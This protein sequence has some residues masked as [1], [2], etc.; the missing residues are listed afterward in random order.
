MGHVRVAIKLAHPERRSDAVTI[1]GALVDAGATHVVL[2]RSIVE[3][4]GLQVIGQIRV[5]TA[6]G[7]QTLDQSYA[8]IELEGRETVTSVL[9]SDTLATVLVGVIALEG[10]GLAV[11]PSTGRLRDSEV[12][13]MVGAGR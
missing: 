12:L 7:L 2:P 3:S 8:Y 1:E 10:I 4:L 6:A 5:M 9:V 11:D 13:L